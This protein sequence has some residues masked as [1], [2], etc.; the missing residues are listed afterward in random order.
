MSLVLAASLS[1]IPTGV[2]AAAVLDVATSP[3]GRWLAMA[4]ALFVASVMLLLGLPAVLSLFTDRAR[5]LGGTAVVLFSI[6]VT[7]SSGYA[8]LLM[9]VQALAVKGGILPSG[10]GPMLDDSGIAAVLFGWVGCFYL[11]TLLIALALFRAR[12]TPAWVP[13]TLLVVVALLPFV[14]MMS[15]VGQVL[16][17]LWAFAFTG[18]ATSVVQRGSRE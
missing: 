1:P 9:F 8:M 10:L 11:A 6:G 16:Q 14:P 13:I 15:H 18:I 17:V 7:G 4:V 5:G 12:S 3:G 2:D